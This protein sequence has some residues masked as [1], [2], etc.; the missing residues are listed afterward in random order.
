MGKTSL[1]NTKATHR[2]ARR[3]I[4][5]NRP[6][7]NNCVVAFVRALSMGDAINENCGRSTAISASIKNHTCFNFDD[8]AI[9]VG[10]V[11]HPNLGWM[12]MHVSVE[13]FFS[14]IRNAY[15]ST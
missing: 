3:I 14:P 9:G 10:V 5:T 6:A 11:F 1:H 4:G 7:I 15:W 2:T 8:L 12:S 13:A